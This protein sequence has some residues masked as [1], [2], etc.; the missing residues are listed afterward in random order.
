MGKRELNGERMRWESY[1]FNADILPFW[2]F[3]VFL[4]TY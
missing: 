1:F 2:E 3:A 4:A